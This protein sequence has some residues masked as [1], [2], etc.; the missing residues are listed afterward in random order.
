MVQFMQHNGLEM[1]KIKDF[2]KNI[3]WNDHRIILVVVIVLLVLLMMD[4]NNR[5]TLMLKLNE[6]RDQLSTQVFRL[7]QT[8]QS[9]EKQVAYA[10][11]ERALEEYAREKAKLIE[12]GDVPIIILTPAGQQIN[13]TPKPQATQEALTRFEVWQEL[14][15]GD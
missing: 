11:S 9:F 6:Q 12:E 14:F 2:F 1:E 15:F 3:K 4:F 13:P 7:E 10:T 8:K 5:M